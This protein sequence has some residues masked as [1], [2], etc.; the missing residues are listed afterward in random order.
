MAMAGGGSIPLGQIALDD[1]Y[2]VLEKELEK[3]KIF[4]KRAKGY[5]RQLQ[6]V[7]NRVSNSVTIHLD[8]FEELT[9]NVVSKK[10]E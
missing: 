10:K 9:G 2:P 6:E 5:Q 8:D 1:E 4:L 3:C 7:A